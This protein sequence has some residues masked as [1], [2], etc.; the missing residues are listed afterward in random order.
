MPYAFPTHLQSL[1][2]SVPAEIRTGL[3]NAELLARVTEVD[4]LQ[5]Q[6]LAETIPGNHDLLSRRAWSVLRALSPTELDKQVRELTTKAADA[7]IGLRVGYI[8]RAR[9][10]Q[11]D[12]PQVDATAVQGAKKIV[13]AAKRGG[14][15]AGRRAKAAPVV[16]LKR[17]G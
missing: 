3:S 13:K 12:N 2:D 17:A 7:P 6:A 9:K 15:R 11:E 4:R 5:K 8:E 16:L 1:V 10:L 14:K